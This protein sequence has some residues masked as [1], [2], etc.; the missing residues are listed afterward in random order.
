[1]RYPSLSPVKARLRVRYATTGLY[2]LIFLRLLT[3]VE[4]NKGLRIP[5][6]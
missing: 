6:P 5:S 3:L 4:A 1:M 2:V